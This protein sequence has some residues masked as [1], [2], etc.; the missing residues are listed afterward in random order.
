MQAFCIQLIGPAAFRHG[1]GMVL[2]CYHRNLV[3]ASLQTESLGLLVSRTAKNRRNGEDFYSPDHR[4]C[5]RR[6][7]NILWQLYAGDYS[8]YRSWSPRVQI[9][10]NNLKQELD[11]IRDFFGMSR[12]TPQQAVTPTA[13]T[14]TASDKRKTSPQGTSAAA[15]PT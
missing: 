9:E 3:F 8:T 13:T 15:N 10:D 4:E 11:D 6:A 1:V 14:G 5:V 12:L 2:C 7:S